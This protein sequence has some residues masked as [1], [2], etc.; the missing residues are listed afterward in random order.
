MF[1]RIYKRRKPETDSQLSNG[2]VRKTDPF[3]YLVILMMVIFRLVIT[4]M[5]P[6]RIDMGG[7]LAWSN[8]LAMNGPAGIYSRYHIVYA[9]FYLYLLWLSGI[10]A[11]YFGLS[12]HAHIYLIKLWSVIFEAIGAV[13][14]FRMARRAG[15]RTAGIAAA[16][17]YSLN[18]AVFMNSSVWGQFDSIP[19]TM[20]LDSIYFLV[21]EKRN[22]G[23]LLFLA[24]VLTKPQSGLLAPIVLYLYFRDFRFDRKCVAALVSVLAAGVG[25]Y[26]A[27]VLPFYEPTDLCGTAVPAFLDPFWWLFDHYLSSMEDYPFAT[28]NGFNFWTLAGGQIQEDSL[29]FLGLTYKSW[30]YIL[31]LL[32]AVYVF[33][34]MYKGKGSVMAVIYCSY[35]ILFSAFMF[36]TRM[37][38]RYLLPAVIFIVTAAAY[39]RIH[40]P[41][42]VLTSLCVFVN[43]LVI[44][45]ISFKDVYWLS[46]WDT[47]AVLFALATMAT[48]ILA[49]ANGYRMFVQKKPCERGLLNT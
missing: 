23:A 15:K 24:A 6:Y 49:M 10:L 7:Y 33:F 35:L 38:E 28:A 3:I 12:A 5:E 43:Q 37:H 26:L 1:L 20:L 17:C 30:G 9:P 4:L 11:D 34:L 22:T 40:I 25:I 48:Y 18:P 45:I 32:S 44:Y 41:A 27:V 16:S 21:H 39:E 2:T 8:Y 13:I 36:M 46:R 29:P 31:L 14:I 47:T 42:A 19:A